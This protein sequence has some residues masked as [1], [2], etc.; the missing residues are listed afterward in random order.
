MILMESPTAARISGMTS[1]VPGADWMTRPPCVET[2]MPAQPA[3]AAFSAPAAVMTP[4]A[5]KGI[6]TELVSSRSSASLLGPSWFTA[7]PMLAKPA[8]STS[9]AKAMQPAASISFAREMSFSLSAQG[10]RVM[11]FRPSFSFAASRPQE[12][13]SGLALSPV[14][15]RMPAAF[16]PR[17]RA[18]VQSRSLIAPL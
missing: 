1:Q 15:G 7:E 11:T 13:C 8:A 18:K 9:Q 2:M 10:L 3:R 17:T 16:A 4:L 12:Y 14:K 6:L 5:R